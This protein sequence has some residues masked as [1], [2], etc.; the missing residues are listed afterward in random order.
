MTTAPN[1]PK[2][3]QDN[4]WRHNWREGRCVCCHLTPEHV[5][6]RCWGVAVWM[7]VGKP[8]FKIETY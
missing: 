1:T 5:G 2:T 8:I 3:E 4:P 6:E 7:P